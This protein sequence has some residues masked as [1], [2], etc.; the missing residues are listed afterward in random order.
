MTPAI[1]LLF[2]FLDALLV[3]ITLSTSN[4]S[5]ELFSELVLLRSSRFQRLELSAALPTSPRHDQKCSP[6]WQRAY[7]LPISRIK[8]HRS[9]P[10]TPLHQALSGTS[11]SM[12]PLPDLDLYHNDQRVLSLYAKDAINFTISANLLLILCSLATPD[13]TCVHHLE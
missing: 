8:R 6:P 1:P 7:P 5:S 3:A 11:S 4:H 9:A 10:C 13:P 2:T 12:V